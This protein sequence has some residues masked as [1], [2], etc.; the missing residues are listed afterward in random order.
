MAIT[1][2]TQRHART[3][4]PLI[5]VSDAEMAQAVALLKAGV[6]Q[7]NLSDTA[8]GAISKY[9]RG[10]RWQ[11]RTPGEQ[12]E[13]YRNAWWDAVRGNGPAAEKTQRAQE[14]ARTKLLQPGDVHVD[15]MLTNLAVKYANDEYIGDALSPEILVSKKTDLI[16]VWDRRSR[17]QS[18][19]DLVGPKGQV[20]AI[21]QTT[22]RTPY[23]L[24]SRGLKDEIPV[25]TI[26]NQDAPYEFQGE[27]VEFVT[28]VMGL[29][30]ERR[31]STVLTTASNYGGNTA[32]IPA[33]ERWNSATGGDPLGRM[34]AADAAL[35][36]GMGP[37]MKMQFSDVTVYNVLAKHPEILSL[38]AFSGG[39]VGLAT[40]GM[41]AQF[42]G[43]E[44]Y[45]VGRARYDTA[46]EA[47]AESAARIWPAKWGLVRV[48]RGAATL[49][50]AFFS[51]TL[52]WNMM[53]LPGELG[54]EELARNGWVVKTWWD[55]KEGSYGMY[56]TKV[57]TSEQTRVIAADTGFL[58]ETPIN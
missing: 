21:T 19:D 11:G 13:D 16:A 53:G 58:Y 22:S 18:P 14:Q 40:P 55:D 5:P 27:S 45:L 30:R 44:D 39:T 17:M 51:G 34:L 28:E 2:G 36:N 47:Q 7:R 46:N 37:T 54:V 35:W 29:N 56:Y 50:N 24:E 43:A 23:A 25:E 15:A 31:Q 8:I 4:Q 32:A 1:G 41:I 26:A 38:Y 20:N 12:Y 33:A 10:R 9:Q 42:L 6:G 52:R 57:V 49:R 48:P 3:G